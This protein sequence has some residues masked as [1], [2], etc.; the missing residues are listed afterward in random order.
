MAAN[1]DVQEEDDY[2]SNC[3][4]ESAPPAPKVDPRQ[5]LPGWKRKARLEEKHFKLQQSQKKG[6]L[7]E[8]TREEGL[9]TPISSSNKGFAMLVKMGFKV[10]EGLG[11]DGSGRQEPVPI[12][13]KQG[14]QGLGKE[15]AKKEQ[16]EAKKRVHVARLA[17]KERATQRSAADFRARK[18]LEFIE[19]QAERD[20]PP[21]QRACEQLDLTAGIQSNELWYKLPP[22]EVDLRYGIPEESKSTVEKPESEFDQLETS[23]KLKIVTNYLRRVHAYCHWCGS[24]FKSDDDL[25]TNCPGDD[26]ESHQ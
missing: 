6:K 14:K 18:R 13:V 16:E 21:S 12:H 4:L 22:P 9:A 7:M 1:S 24:A 11:K 10:G 15:R 3:F 17:Q 2:M 19:K 5:E 25:A 20:L 26:W 23:E 8:K